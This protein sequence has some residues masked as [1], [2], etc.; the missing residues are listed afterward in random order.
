V[1]VH[2]D[3]HHQDGVGADGLP[4]PPPPDAEL[5]ALRVRYLGPDRRAGRSIRNNSPDDEDDVLRAAGFVGPERVS[6]R[7]GRVVDRSID[8]LVDETLSKSS[9][10]PHLFGDRLEVFERDL[11]RLL[12]RASPTGLFS[13]LLPDNELKIW[14]ISPG[15]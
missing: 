14:R 11:R 5:D 10:A 6:V 8:A 3:N 12:G 1:L 9:T 15:R 13:A 2:V 7:D 4:H